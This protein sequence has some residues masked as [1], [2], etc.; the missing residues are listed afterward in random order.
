MII[1]PCFARRPLQLPGHAGRAVPM[2]S[3]CFNYQTLVH[4]LLALVPKRRRNGG[5]MA[6]PNAGRL[7]FRGESP[8]VPHEETPCLHIHWLLTPVPKH[9]RAPNT[10][11][12]VVQWRFPTQARSVSEGRA[13]QFPMKRRRIYTSIGCSRRFPNAGALPTQAQWRFNGVSQRRRGIR[14]RGVRVIAP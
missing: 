11:A 10:G 7:R 14:F 4:W 5:S 12:M 3:R 6:F 8:S 13:L 1:C 9:R 2:K